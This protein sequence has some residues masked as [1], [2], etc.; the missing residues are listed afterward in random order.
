MGFLMTKTYSLLSPFHSHPAVFARVR[1]PWRRTGSEATL[2]RRH[3]RKSVGVYLNLLPLF[4]LFRL[5]RTTLR[6]AAPLYNPHSRN[7]RA[8]PRFSPTR[9]I[10]SVAT[11]AISLE[12]DYL[13]ALRD[14]TLYVRL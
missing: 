10:P 7:V 2:R 3:H 5:R 13:Q 8:A 14:K 1:L 12:L 9:F 6:A 4:D 11:S